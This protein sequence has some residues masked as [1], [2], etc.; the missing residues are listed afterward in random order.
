M[1]A[2]EKEISLAVD[3]LFY[4]RHR[5]NLLHLTGLVHVFRDFIVSDFT[6]SLTKNVN[7]LDVSE[8]SDLKIQ[9][10]FLMYKITQLRSLQ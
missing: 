4:M 3:V 2:E 10:F 1:Q 9:F 6:R 8:I 5:D 7:L